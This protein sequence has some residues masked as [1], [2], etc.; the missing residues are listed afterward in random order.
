MKRK[1]LLAAL[2]VVGAMGGVNSL[3]AQTDVT[4]TYLTNADFS[5]SYTQYTL[6][7]GNTALGS[8]RFIYQPAG[9]DI[10]VVNKSQWNMTVVK[11][12]DP[13]QNDNFTGTY[14]PGDGK[15]MV[16]LRDNNTSE[17]IDLSQTI[18]I[19]VSGTYKVSARMIRENGNQITVQLYVGNKSVE[20]SSGGK[21]ETR[22]VT[23][24]LTA[25]QEVKVGVKFVNK[26]ATGV[27]AGADYVKIEY[28]ENKTLVNLIEKAEEYFPSLEA[29]SL[30]TALDEA[31]DTKNNFESTDE[32]QTRLENAISGLR[33]A[34]KAQ[35][36]VDANMTLAIVNP[37]FED[38]ISETNAPMGWTIPNKGNDYGVRAV[39]TSGSNY[40][41][42]NADGDYLFN[43]WQSWWM[44]CNLSQ[45]VSDLPNGRYVLSAVVA[46]YNGSTTTLTANSVSTSMVTTG[47][48]NGLLV[49]ATVDV[50]D[51]TLAIGANSVGTSGQTFLKVDNFTL[52]YK[53]LKPVL[54]DA[55]ATA[56]SLR[57]SNVG[58]EA[59]Q[60]PSSA[61]SALNSAISAAQSVN[62]NN[63]ATYDE[64]ETAIGTLNTAIEAFK[65]TELNAPSAGIQYRIKA[66]A[67]S[68]GW[69]GKYYT[70]YYNKGQS[71]GNHSISANKDAAD[72][73]AQAWLFTA[74]AGTTN[75]YTLSMIDEAGTLRYICT[76]QKGYGSGSTTQ[77]RTTTEASK[78][79]VVKVVAATGTDGRWFLQ[80]TEDGSYIGGQDEGF[81]SNSQN[82]D[83]AIEAASQASVTVA[84]KA[85]KFA[86][87][88]FP[89]TPDV[90][91]G[92]DDITFYNCAGENAGVATL[93]EVT[94]LAANTPYLIKNTGTSD[95]ST[96]LSGWGTAS[97]IQYAKGLLT[98]IY[99]AAT[100]PAG[101][102]VLQTPKSTGVQAF[103]PLASELTGGTPNRCYLTLPA[104][105]AK[106]N[107]IF[108][109][110][111]EGTTGIE[112]PNATNGEDGVFYNLAGQRVNRSYKGIIIHNRKAKLNN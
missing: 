36:T 25:G 52:T 40:Y 71:Q 111:E 84:A 46:G 1:L 23:V 15:Y 26:G 48:T 105:A 28:V 57:A 35:K 69:A 93:E 9:W 83:L 90:S 100:I 4:S 59:F 63:D 86:T 91:T 54:A 87:V 68:T 53:G 38:D 42:S 70:M 30:K 89:F 47:A 11:N 27:K 21:W 13:Q 22:D 101:S 64:V 85:S 112:A 55:I 31:K 18:T 107:A 109:D 58:S 106:R 108:F 94:T 97:E 60:I 7:N 12:G 80:N 17:Y 29:G 65:G 81:Y 39:G 98:G 14:E 102:Y 16:R 5:G 96:D 103:Y 82:Y 99:T 49:S 95:F 3:S 33:A 10:S 32:Y 77:I 62:D 6:P 45:T 88:I 8:N 66:T 19:K 24:Y 74:S 73:F 50:N 43:N 78:A 79:L 37:N 92:F 56:T 34:V 44:T 2:C 20:N 104:S 75:G 110:K 67:G 51:N 76:A 72:Y 61:A 41:M